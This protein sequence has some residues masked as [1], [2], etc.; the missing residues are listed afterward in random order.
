MLEDYKV[1]FDDITFD[2][3]DLGFKAKGAG[4]CRH[5]AGGYRYR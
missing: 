5:P 1:R 3:V 4:G 2:C